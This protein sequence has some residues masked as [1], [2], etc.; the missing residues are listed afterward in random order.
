VQILNVFRGVA[1]SKAA[2]TIMPM[3]A[4]NQTHP[5][6]QSEA[7]AWRRCRRFWKI[8]YRDCLAPIAEPRAFAIGTAVHSGL[9]SYWRADPQI[10][11][12]RN[13]IT[14]HDAFVIEYM[15]AYYGGKWD[16]KQSAF[17]EVKVEQ[18]FSTDVGGVKIQGKWDAIARVDGRLWI[19][20]HKTA[21]R[22][23][24]SYLSRL[25]SDF[26][27]GFYA[28][29]ARAVFGETPA[30]VLYDIIE[31][32]PAA[33][34]SPRSG[35]TDGEFRLRQ[36][37]AKMPGRCKR[38]MDQSFDEWE[39]SLQSFFRDESHF[40]RQEITLS[41]DDLDEVCEEIK[42]TAADIA[43]GIIY[44]NTDSCFGKYGI[45]CPYWYFCQSRGDENIVSTLYENR[46][47][48]IELEKGADDDR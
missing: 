28:V 43:G 1:I 16:H 44:R 32:P 15:L 33:M 45:R 14:E 17:S 13:G 8:R 20:E 30:G 2:H 42:A 27:V 26:Q 46:N 3:N 37:A 6:T 29:A 40:V 31:K 23:D 19:I 5:I 4:E 9:E 18:R 38:K 41:E 7:A 48:Y 36:E 11:F 47:P 39:N 24:G 22:V 35:E 12:P 21:S 10:S 25:W 34:W